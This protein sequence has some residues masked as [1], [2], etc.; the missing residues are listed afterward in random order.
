VQAKEENKSINR[1]ASH[2]SFAGLCENENMLSKRKLHV[3]NKKES[4]L[5]LSQTNIQI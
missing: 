2:I 5:P 4:R 1:A 3:Q